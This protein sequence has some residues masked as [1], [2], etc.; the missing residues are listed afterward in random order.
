MQA[1]T[2]IIGA[3][4]HGL[5][6][7]WHL[8]KEQGSGDGIVILDKTTPGAGAT[9]VACGVV[10]NYYVQHPM[11]ALMAASVD[12]WEANSQ[13]LGYHPSGYLAVAPDV[14]VSDLEEIHARHES[15]GY[16]A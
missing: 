15:L 12:I 10:R 5:S 14:M 2:I 4:I 13:L 6:T 9:G 16:P 1:N 3:G 8:A 7:A 11:G